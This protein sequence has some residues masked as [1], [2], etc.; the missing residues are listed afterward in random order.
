[1]TRLREL[2]NGY[3]KHFKTNEKYLPLNN[4][5]ELELAYLDSFYSRENGI[6]GISEVFLMYNVETEHMNT[7]V[8]SDGISYLIHS[9]PMT[10][11]NLLWRMEQKGSRGIDFDGMAIGNVWDWSDIL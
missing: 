1:M 4:K 2:L 5:N 8:S 11:E 3:N 7:Y 6:E 10:I 9:V